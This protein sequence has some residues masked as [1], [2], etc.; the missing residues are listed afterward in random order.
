MRFTR[1][2]NMKV[3]MASFRKLIRGL[4]EAGRDTQMPCRTHPSTQHM[5]AQP[6]GTMH[7]RLIV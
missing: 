6:S 3:M 2:R 7:A 5:P 4:K 1:N